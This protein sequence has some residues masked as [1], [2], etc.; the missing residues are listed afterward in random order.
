MTLNCHY[1]IALV[2]D[3]VSD[4]RHISYILM[5]A[6]HNN[7]QNLEILLWLILT[8]VPYLSFCVHLSVI[9]LKERKSFRTHIFCIAL[10]LLNH[11]S[12]RFERNVLGSRFLRGNAL[13]IMYFKLYLQLVGCNFEK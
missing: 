4:Y 9:S 7:G 11:R 10:Q 5:S 12:F 3:I 13:F 2:V 1:E 8:N 6:N